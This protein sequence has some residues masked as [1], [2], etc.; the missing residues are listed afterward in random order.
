MFK[1]VGQTDRQIL[2][3]LYFCLIL[4]L[5]VTILEDEKK[6][7]VSRYDTESLA[8]AWTAGVILSKLTS[9]KF[10]IAYLVREFILFIHRSPTPTGRL[11]R[12]KMFHG[13]NNGRQ[14]DQRYCQ[15]VKHRRW[16]G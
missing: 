4:V 6:I 11:C 1:L 3:A 5:C 13:R 15:L 2:L 8:V 9:A 10:E 16:S 12:I 7:T 14:G